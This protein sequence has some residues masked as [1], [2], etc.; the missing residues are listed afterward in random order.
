[1]YNMKKIDHFISHKINDC[2]NKTVVITGANSGLG[3]ETA[4]VLAS[5][6][7]HI[8]MACRSFER[9]NKAKQNIISEYPNSRIDILEYDQSSFSSIDNFIV[10]LK[11]VSKIATI[12]KG[13]IKCYL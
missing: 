4:K 3:F 2:N 11:K 7:A 6:G 5:K 1:M 12:F 8:I 13:D 10:Q 9:A